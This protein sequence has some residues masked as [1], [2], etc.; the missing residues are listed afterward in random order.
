MILRLFV[1]KGSNAIVIFAGEL[2]YI[3]MITL[4]L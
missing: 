2:L 4:M 1:W 3:N